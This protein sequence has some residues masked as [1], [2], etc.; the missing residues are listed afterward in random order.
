MTYIKNLLICMTILLFLGCDALENPV[1]ETN[2][3]YEI[4]ASAELIVVLRTPLSSNTNQRGDTFTTALKDV[5]FKKKALK[6]AVA[7][8]EKMTKGKSQEQLTTIIERYLS[9]KLHIEAGGLRRQELL[10]KLPSSDNAKALIAHLDAIEMA[11]YG[12]GASQEELQKKTI[13]LLTNINKEL[14]S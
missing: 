7:S 3:G 1:K 14:R 4:M 9:A 10:E 5:F 2:E 12:G 8:I 13:E 11:Q 6:K